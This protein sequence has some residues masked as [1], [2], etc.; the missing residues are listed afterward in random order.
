MSDSMEVYQPPEQ[1]RPWL[2]PSTPNDP[3]GSLSILQILEWPE[4]AD[5]K[6]EL[7]DPRYASRSHGGRSTYALKCRGPLCRY[8][9]RFRGRKRNQKKAAQAGREYVEGPTRKYDRDDLLAAIIV[10]HR[11]DLALRKIDAAS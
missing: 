9:E 8:A 1:R 2:V 7:A 3:E 6:E 4:M 10:W 5:V 11:R